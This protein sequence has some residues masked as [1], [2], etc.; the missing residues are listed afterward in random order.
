MFITLYL[1]N[2]CIIPAFLQLTATSF[3]NY[4]HFVS[5]KS[6][7]L[8][9]GL[10]VSVIVNAQNI[11][12]GTA[13]PTNRLHVLAASN[14][15]KLEGLVTGAAADEILTT[16]ATGVVRR[17]TVA[18]VTSGSGWLL[19]GNAATNIATQFI[20]TTDAVSL[21]FRTFNQR[22]GFIDFD[23]TKRNNSFGN[24]AMS[25]TITG[26]GNNAFGYMAMRFLST[27]V[28]NVA[29]GDSTGYNV[30]S[31]TDNILIGSDAGRAITLGSQN[32]AIGS[33]SLSGEGAGS[34]NVGIGHRALEVSLSSDNIGIGSLTL[35]KNLTGSN[36]IAIGSNALTNYIGATFNIGV[37]NDALTAVTT[38]TEN[39][40]L[41]YRAGYTLSTQI[42]NTLLGNYTLG[43]IGAVSGANYNTMVGY[44]AGGNMT[45]GSNNVGIGFL[46]GGTIVTSSNNTF[47]GYTADVTVGVTAL[48]NS[49]A[50]GYQAVASANNQYRFGNSSVTSIGGQVGWTTL[51]DE[52]VKTDVREDVIGL[53]FISRLRP[54]TYNYD[55]R[56]I[57]I[58]QRGDKAAAE[59]TTTNAGTRFS[60]FLAQEVLRTSGAAGY[61]FSGVDMPGNDKTLYGLRYAEFVVPLVKAVQELKAIVDK[62]QAEI[63]QMELKLQ[64][65]K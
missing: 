42:Q 58:M 31:G 54:V 46:A 40:A 30:N 21:A 16:D 34:N 32:V 3:P 60:G 10:C 7:F 2:F 59:Y 47:V 36:S 29:L 17:R 23:S 13:T 62:Q 15:L 19:T 6:A 50:F 25:T 56:K 12:I 8:A 5:M 45:A 49:A 35:N 55:L 24:R 1:N 22:S 65:K 51:S 27:G 44:Q 37:G 53:D 11:G 43:N 48:T 9:I 52:R 38:G 4:I 18:S 14:P 57:D 26:N 28:N 61:N 64:E 41:G 33:R 20:G 63:K 39:V